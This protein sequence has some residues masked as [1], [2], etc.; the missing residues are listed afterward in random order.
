MNTGP[1]GNDIGLDV[2]KGG[3]PGGLADAMPSREK[4]WSELTA[5]EKIERMRSEIKGLRSTN[6]YQASMIHKL[7]SAFY[8]HSH[9]MQNGYIVKRLVEWEEQSLNAPYCGATLAK[10][11]DPNNTYF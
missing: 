6:E 8:S 9:D 4:Y 10:N 2:P 5:D 7:R 1:N 11:T 3:V